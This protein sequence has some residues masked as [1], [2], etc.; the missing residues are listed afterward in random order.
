MLA[1]RYKGKDNELNDV[2]AGLTANVSKNTV[3]IDTNTVARQKNTTVIEG[4]VV[5]NTAN[6]DSIKKE[7]I[8]LEENIAL[9]NKKNSE[10]QEKNIN[11]TFNAAPSTGAIFEDEESAQRKQ[12]AS[13]AS[14]KNI[15]D[16]TQAE[17]E[18]LET[19]QKLAKQR[20]L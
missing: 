4:Q 6:A 17:K 15:N 2:V 12:I 18:A 9:Q 8:A 7:N 1:D 5:S 16:L 3:N 19:E 14:T 11:Q 10:S 20:Q 13:K